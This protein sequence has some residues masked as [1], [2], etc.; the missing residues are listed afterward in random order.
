MFRLTSSAKFPTKMLL[1]IEWHN[2]SIGN[3]TWNKKWIYN[4][5]QRCIDAL[6]VMLLAQLILQECKI[7][8]HLEKKGAHLR[9]VE[10]LNLLTL[11]FI[12]FTPS[13]FYY[14]PAPLSHR[15]LLSASWSKVSVLP[16]LNFFHSFLNFLFL[17]TLLSSLALPAKCVCCVRC[18]IHMYTH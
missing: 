8:V 4:R 16:D 3:G 6:C 18:S 2:K 14:S 17:I 10:V 7:F 11:P 9:S 1:V 5:V 15:L 13:C 12:F